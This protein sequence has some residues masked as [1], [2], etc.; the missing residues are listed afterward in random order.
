MKKRITGFLLLMMTLL[1]TISPVYAGALGG[2]VL[3]DEAD[4]LS[5]SDEIRLGTDLQQV[6]EKYAM[7]VRILILDDYRAYSD[8]DTGSAES[9]AMS[10]YEQ[11]SFTDDGIVLMLS[12]AGG[13]GNRDWHMYI[14][15]DA[16]IAVN[17]YGFEYISERLVDEL[18]NEN[19]DD[20]IC[21][22]VDDIK[23]FM[24]EYDKGTPYGDD[25]KARSPMDYFM[26]FGIG[27]IIAFVIALVIVL[28]M[29]S[30]MNTA[31]PQPF[32]REY[33]KKDSF[34]LTNQQ[35]I[36]L[37][38]N[39]TKTAIPKNNSSGGGRS[40]GSRGGSGGGGKF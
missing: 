1:M 17:N 28:V 3:I 31:K 37:Y 29:R 7:D 16:Q 32:A 5:D 39:T 26:F 30:S 36:Y 40:S 25:H 23:D 19:F 18:S 13:E 12:L 35:D 27:I 21:T 4:V 14:S 33:V 22:Y 34:V 15:G 6:A 9:F 8:Y 2:Y 38:S 11:E 20:G 10:F 24:Q